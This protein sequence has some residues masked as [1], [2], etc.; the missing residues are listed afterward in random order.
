LNALPPDLNVPSACP[1][2]GGKWV[3][4]G[5]QSAQVTVFCD[6]NHFY[7]RDSTPAEVITFEKAVYPDKHLTKGV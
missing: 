3:G 7:D 1:Q 4:F 6:E 2:Y 5:T